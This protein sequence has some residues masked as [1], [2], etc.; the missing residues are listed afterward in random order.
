[1]PENRKR[2][3]DIR[4]VV[5][6]MADEG[7]FLELKADHAAGIIT[8]LLRVDGKPMGLIAN[9]PMHLGGAIDAAASRKAATFPRSEEQGAV[10]AASSLISAGANLRTPIIFI[11]LRKGYGLGAQAMAGGSFTAPVATLS[12]PTGEFGPMGLEGGVELGFKREL[13]AQSTPEAR[14]SLF[15]KL[16]ADAYQ[17]GG[18]INVASLLEI[19]AVIDPMETRKWISKCL[20]L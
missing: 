10:D 9:N 12:W 6:V 5:R 20:D 19:G 7:S 13:E 16:L 11:C 8:G 14:Q 3:Y 18:A 1:M 17:R 4:A 15:N 2:G